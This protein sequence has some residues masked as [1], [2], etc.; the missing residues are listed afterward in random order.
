[1]VDSSSS[2]GVRSGPGVSLVAG[3]LRALR[4]PLASEP[5][6]RGVRD[7]LLGP[8]LL[9]GNF[10]WRTA[11]EAA[12]GRGLLAYTDGGN[13]MRGLPARGSPIEQRE[14]VGGPAGV[15]V[16]AA[17]Y[18]LS[19]ILVEPEEPIHP[20]RADPFL[21]LPSPLLRPTDLSPLQLWRSAFRLR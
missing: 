6:E 21:H 20:R 5:S 3:P 12:R 16:R 18:S 11:A 10:T 8:R 9:A 7:H 17:R 2:F 1:M 4:A 13:E 14:P 15:R 19:E